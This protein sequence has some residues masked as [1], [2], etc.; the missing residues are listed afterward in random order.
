MFQSSNVHFC[1]CLSIDLI[2]GILLISSLD[3]KDSQLEAGNVYSAYDSSRNALIG[4]GAI[5][6]LIGANNAYGII[7]EQPFT[8]ISNVWVGLNP[9]MKRAPN[10]CHA[11]FLR[12]SAINCSVGV[13]G[14]LYRTYIDAAPRKSKPCYH[15]S[16]YHIASAIYVSAVFG[17]TL[18]NAQL[19]VSGTFSVAL[20]YAAFD[21]GDVSPTAI[22]VENSSFSGRIG[23]DGSHN[24]TYVAVQDIGRPTIE[25]RSALIITNAALGFEPSG[26]TY[27]HRLFNLSGDEDVPVERYSDFRYAGGLPTT[28]SSEGQGTASAILS[29]IKARLT[30]GTDGSDNMTY[31]GGTCGFAVSDTAGDIGRYGNSTYVN[32][33]IGVSPTGVVVGNMYGIRI[34]GRTDTKIGSSKFGNTSYV[35]GIAIGGMTARRC[36]RTVIDN[37]WFGVNKDGQIYGNAR[38]TYFTEFAGYISIYHSTNTTIG[39]DGEQ[40]APV[41]ICGGNYGIFVESSSGVTVANSIIG[42]APNGKPAGNFLGGVAL[43]DRVY[44]NNWNEIFVNLPQDYNNAYQSMDAEFIMSIGVDGSQT[45]VVISCNGYINQYGRRNSQVYSHLP[46]FEKKTCTNNQTAISIT[47]TYIGLNRE[48]MLQRCSGHDLQETATNHSDSQLPVDYFNSSSGAV[49]LG[50]GCTVG[51]PRGNATYIMP[52]DVPAITGHCSAGNCGTTISNVIVG[53]DVHGQAQGTP[54][55]SV[56]MLRFGPLA[57]SPT[58]LSSML[59]NSTG[60]SFPRSVA[61]KSGKCQSSNLKIG[62]H[63]AKPVIIHT[64]MRNSATN[65]TSPGFLAEHK[66]V[67][68]PALIYLNVPNTMVQNVHASSSTQEHKDGIHVYHNGFRIGNDCTSCR[69]G[70]NVTVR[71]ASICGILSEASNMTVINTTVT[72]NGFAGLDLAS[73]AQGGVIT[74]STFNGNGWNP[75]TGIGGGAIVAA[76][77]STWTNNSFGKVCNPSG[78]AGTNDT[79]GTNI[80]PCQRSGNR[81]YGMWIQS[82][83][84]GTVATGNVVTESV[85]NGIRDDTDGHRLQSGGSAT[86]SSYTTNN[87][88]DAT[89]G[90]GLA[91]CDGTASRLCLCTAAKNTNAPQTN[92]GAPLRLALS[93]DCTGAGDLGANFPTQLPQTTCQLNLRGVGLEHVEWSSLARLRGPGLAVLDLGDNPKLDV[94]P[95]SGR[96]AVADFPQL[97]ALNLRGTNM[98]RMANNS[99]VELKR[100]LETLDLSAPSVKAKP[101]VVL[102]L[103]GFAKLRVFQTDRSDCPAGYYDSNPEYETDFEGVVLCTRCDVGTYKPAGRRRCVACSNNTRDHDR[104][105]STPCIERLQFKVLSYRRGSTVYTRA[106]PTASSSSSS[107]SSISS[108]KTAIPA[109]NVDT[110]HSSEVLH[111][112]AYHVPSNIS[113]VKIISSVFQTGSV[114]FLVQNLPSGLLFDPATGYIE[115]VPLSKPDGL[116]GIVTIHS[117]LS[118]VDEASNKAVIETMKINILYPDTANPSNGPLGRGC[119]HNSAVVDVTPFNRHFTCNCNYTVYTGS[120]CQ[121]KRVQHWLI[122]AVVAGG[123]LLVGLCVSGWQVHRARVLRYGPHSFAKMIAALESKSVLT[124]EVATSQSSEGDVALLLSGAGDGDESDDMLLGNSD[125]GG[126]SVDDDDPATALTTNGKKKNQQRKKKKKKKK[127]QKKTGKGDRQVETLRLLPT[128]LTGTTTAAA[129]INPTHKRVVRCKVPVE[130]AAADLEVLAPIGSGWS[131]EVSRALL[132]HIPKARSRSRWRGWF[133]KNANLP[134]QECAV[135]MPTRGSSPAIRTMLLEEAALMA[136]FEHPNVVALFGVVTRKQQCLIVLE[137]CAKGSLF[138]LLR[139]ETFHVGGEENIRIEIVLAIARD[140]TAGMKYMSERHFVHRDLASRNILVD[141]QDRCKVSDFGMSRLLA[142]NKHYYYLQHAGGSPLPLRWSAPEV[143]LSGR[144]TTGSD[145]WSFGVLLYELLTRAA[146]PFARCSNVRVL[147]VLSSECNEAVMSTYLPVPFAGARSIY[148]MLVVPCWQKDV[149][150]RPLFTHILILLDELKAA[151]APHSFVGNRHVAGIAHATKETEHSHSSYE[152]HSNNDLSSWM[153]YGSGSSGASFG[154][155]SSFDFAR[156][157]ASSHQNDLRERVGLAQR[158]SFRSINDGSSS[159]SS[160]S[161]ATR[162]HDGVGYL[163]G[164]PRRREDAGAASL[165]VSL[166]RGRID[167]TSADA[168]SGDGNARASTPE[169]GSVGSSS[170]IFAD[171]SV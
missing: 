6:T 113:G 47:N 66:R 158:A 169:S 44:G 109:P 12:H 30:L 170:G 167:R 136:Q 1:A 114:T 21:H 127:N 144:F 34:Y 70:P 61:K 5:P 17:F 132:I 124:L 68:L 57:L 94:L 137:L 168:D 8:T 24:L 103:T 85:W 46:E 20:E 4:N 48:G 155:G 55:S 93:V 25:S 50:I 128:A 122:A 78:T 64:S 83:A 42:L 171:T 121:V 19:G 134:R 104:D 98:S 117:V 92:N 95:A 147:E 133:A 156:L 91:A 139:N 116:N 36:R 151:G 80:S 53:L 32:F 115:G 119:E 11:I 22:R 72:G 56:E 10:S 162:V 100:T 49:A 26:M 97:V 120:N 141:D 126:G 3:V 107:S 112:L 160:G 157:L 59:A 149:L 152:S 105:P 79:G 51:T 35:L 84:S 23:V 45:P 130:I 2:S 29:L 106:V 40:N 15:E 62:L 140:V 16:K 33:A 54:S 118:A 81:F 52:T 159:S 65:Q 14:S 102:N 96:F 39:V 88:V 27:A 101:G 166:P 38:L 75:T 111:Q 110:S 131:G 18:V 89:N 71:N 161:S 129:G 69:V 143:L 154:S 74:G 28:R 41:Y 145:V 148:E 37:V 90:K 163:V 142:Q 146:I 67:G 150:R 7:V 138:G 123:L 164:R 153:S 86:S 125:D 31:V 165:A 13:D 82:T 60:M 73:T 58:I 63:D 9:A 76:P 43:T 87:Y 77:H 135:K 108:K 99:F